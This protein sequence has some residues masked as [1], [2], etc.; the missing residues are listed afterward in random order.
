M[1]PKQRIDSR[2]LNHELAME[3][4]AHERIP[5]AE[6]DWQDYRNLE[7]RRGGFGGNRASQ[8]IAIGD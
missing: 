6:T 2:A 5:I 7:L 4:Q 1:E 3:N 8:L